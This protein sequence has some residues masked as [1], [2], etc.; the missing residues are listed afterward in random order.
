MIWPMSKEQQTNK[1]LVS[2]PKHDAYYSV[3]V[4]VDE[5]KCPI[6]TNG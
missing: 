1:R 6:L 5:C 4:T 2:A 3:E